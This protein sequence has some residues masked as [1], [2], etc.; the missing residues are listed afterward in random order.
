MAHGMC[1]DAV[2]EASSG[3]ELGGRALVAASAV[4]D[5]HAVS[6]DE[7]ELDA[8]AEPRRR[9]AGVEMV[10]RREAAACGAA[11]S[12]DGLP[13]EVARG[14]QAG[15]ADPHMLREPGEVAE[16]W[17]SSHRGTFSLDRLDPADP[18]ELR[19]RPF[20]DLNPSPQTDAR[21]EPEA[22]PSGAPAVS[23]IEDVVPEETVKRVRRWESR[24]RACLKAAR[25]GNPSLARQLR[26]PDL[27]LRACEHTVPGMERWVWDLRPLSRGERAVPL[28][29]SSRKVPPATDL[30]LAAVE[31]LG[32][33]YP[34]KAIISEMVMGFS[35]DAVDVEKYVVFSP[36][37]LGALRYAAEARAKVEKDV[38]KGWSAIVS[39][40]PFWPVRVNPYSI[41]REERES[42][43]KHRMTIDLSWP[44]ALSLIHI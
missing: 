2:L 19:L 42:G 15:S 33:D 34:D 41:V 4:L 20:P 9:R 6:A 12:L 18:E 35:D 27:E 44:R 13:V 30:D 1:G 38:G 11:A 29:S 36:P 24:V 17:R 23:A 40:L 10:A 14:L 32:M 31:R 22:P 5:A 26:P 28:A 8:G 7:G 25:R 21:R 43:V 37:H 3:G 39:H 16:P